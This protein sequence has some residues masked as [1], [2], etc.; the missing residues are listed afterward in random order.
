[1]TGPE[2]MNSTKS[3]K[4]RPGLVNGVKSL[5]LAARQVSH[6]GGND[7]Q[8]RGLETGIDLANHILGNCVRLD[9]GEGALDGHELS[10]G[11]L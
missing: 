11:F 1:M 10:F 6:F 9:D 3:L 7:L 5:G 2:I 8:A 4:K